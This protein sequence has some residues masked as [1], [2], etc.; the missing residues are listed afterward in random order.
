MLVRISDYSLFSLNRVSS[1]SNRR[2]PSAK[3]HREKLFSRDV[4]TIRQVDKMDVGI[5][6]T[7]N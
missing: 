6:Q 4:R 3:E 1:R 5:N 2:N 7:W